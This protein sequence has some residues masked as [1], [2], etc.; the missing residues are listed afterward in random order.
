[1]AQ[2]QF[3]EGR[4]LLSS[5]KSPQAARLSL[6]EQQDPLPRQSPKLL[7]ELLMQSLTSQQLPAKPRQQQ[8]LR[9]CSPRG[10]GGH[11]RTAGSPKCYISPP[12]SLLTAHDLQLLFQQRTRR[13]KPIY[14]QTAANNQ[15]TH[16]PVNL[17]FILEDQIKSPPLCKIKKL[18]K[19]QREL[20]L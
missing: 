1:M 10:D 5:P 15:N 9:D 7:L 14:Q 17:K 20:R 6:L 18:L 4:G 2:Q 3:R 11:Q 19:Y 16:Q 13:M 8:P 12:S